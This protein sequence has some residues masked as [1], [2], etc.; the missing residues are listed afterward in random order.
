MLT[1]AL[2]W[3]PQ[4]EVERHSAGP[5]SSFT[6]SCLAAA[7]ALPHRRTFSLLVTLF[8]P[9]RALSSSLLRLCLP[10]RAVTLR[11]RASHGGL[12]TSSRAADKA[13]APRS[14]LWP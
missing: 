12:C 14:A 10:Y 1:V 7:S 3:T 11:R 5:P 6:L 9:L 13:G 2:A 8:S 4:L